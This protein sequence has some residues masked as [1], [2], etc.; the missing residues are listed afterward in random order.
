M[1]EKVDFLICGP[2]EQIYFQ[3]PIFFSFVPN[4]VMGHSSVLLSQTGKGNIRLVSFVSGKAALTVGAL[5]SLLSKL[6]FIRFH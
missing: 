6:D 2:S 4:Q 5:S 3:F 1:Y